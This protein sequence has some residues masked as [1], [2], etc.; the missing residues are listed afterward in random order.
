[1]ISTAVC[2]I[3]SIRPLHSEDLLEIASGYRAVVTVEEHSMHGG[4]GSLISSLLMNEGILVPFR[5]IAFP[6]G[7]FV[8]AGPR[9]EIRSFYGIDRQGIVGTVKNLFETRIKEKR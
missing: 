1:G 3:P 9:E 8:K 2:N 6:E 7:I 5:K 4:L